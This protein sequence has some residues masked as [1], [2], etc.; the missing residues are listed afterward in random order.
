M[1]AKCSSEESP[2]KG[3]HFHWV[4]ESWEATEASISVSTSENENESESE[5]E[6]FNDLNVSRT[7]EMIKYLFGWK[8][9]R[10]WNHSVDHTLQCKVQQ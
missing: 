8:F 9:P 4:G 10:G 7:K 2:S 5:S 6:I 1:N 3:F